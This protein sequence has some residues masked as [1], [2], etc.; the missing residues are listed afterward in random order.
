MAKMLKQISFLFLLF[1][2]ISSYAADTVYV[3]SIK[4]KLYQTP[5]FK[6][7]VVKLA[8]RGDKFSILEKKGNWYKISDDNNNYWVARLLV[9]KRK[10][11]N[12]ISVLAN[13]TSSLKNNARRRASSVVTAGAAR[14]LTA[15]S[16]LRANED[17][18]TDYFSL[19]KI[20]A[21]SV[22]DQDLQQFNN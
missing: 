12:K 7:N 17:S 15:D 4:A 21:I 8:V 14:G 18:D 5:D 22:S 13:D 1:F 3:Q 19:R 6:G 16:R 9:S 20:E 11:L 10:P 2:S